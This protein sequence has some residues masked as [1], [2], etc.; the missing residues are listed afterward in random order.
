[1]DRAPKRST[2]L[3]VCGFAVVLMRSDRCELRRTLRN[4][5]YGKP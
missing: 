3:K 4:D 2:K 1:M 5:L